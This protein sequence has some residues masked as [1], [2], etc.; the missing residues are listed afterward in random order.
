MRKLTVKGPRI[1]TYTMTTDDSYISYL[2]VGSKYI[3]IDREVEAQYYKVQCQH[4]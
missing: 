3:T 2:N 4:C 1:K